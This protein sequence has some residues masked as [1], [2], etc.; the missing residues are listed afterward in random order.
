MQSLLHRTQED[1]NL[2]TLEP[3][4]Q[5]SKQK[6][7]MSLEKA[8]KKHTK[9]VKERKEE[10]EKDQKQNKGQAKVSEYQDIYSQ[11]EKTAGIQ[12]I[13]AEN[14][15]TDPEAT[16]GTAISSKSSHKTAS[17]LPQVRQLQLSI[18]NT[19]NNTE[20]LKKPMRD[21]QESIKVIEANVDKTISQLVTSNKIK[22]AAAIE[23]NKKIGNSFKKLMAKFY[24]LLNVL[25]VKLPN[26]QESLG[27]FTL[28]DEDDVNHFI[29]ILEYG[30]T[31]TAFD[32][33]DSSKSALPPGSF[34]KAKV[35]V[36]PNKPSNYTL[37]PLR[38]LE[39][40]LSDAA[41]DTF[42]DWCS[43]I[44]EKE[45]RKWLN[46]L[47]PCKNDKCITRDDLQSLCASLLRNWPLDCTQNFL[48]AEPLFE[49]EGYTSG[50]HQVFKIGE[51]KSYV[52]RFGWSL[53][54]KEHKD[55]LAGIENEK[56]CRISAQQKGLCSPIT[57]I[58][59]ST[60][61]S[62]GGVNKKRTCSGIT[63]RK[64]DY[65][66]YEFLETLVSEKYHTYQDQ[67]FKFLKNVYINMAAKIQDGV[68]HYSFRGGTLNL[69]NTFIELSDTPLEE[70]FIQGFPLI[71]KTSYLVFRLGSFMKLG[72]S[73][74]SIT[75]HLES[76][77]TSFAQGIEE[78]TKEKQIDLSTLNQ[79]IKTW[80]IDLGA[81]ALP[82]PLNFKEY[83]KN[84]P[85]WEYDQLKH[86]YGGI[87]KH[88][89]KENKN[90][91]NYI[92][93]L[94]NEPTLEST[95]LEKA[96]LLQILNLPFFRNYHIS[97]IR[98]SLSIRGALFAAN[99]KF[100]T[101]EKTLLKIFLGKDLKNKKDDVYILC[102]TYTDEFKE[103]KQAYEKTIGT[104]NKNILKLRFAE[105]ILPIASSSSK[106]TP[107][108][109][110]IIIDSFETL[111]DWIT[112]KKDIKEQM[113]PFISE[114]VM[115]LNESL[116]KTNL[117]GKFDLSDLVVLDREL[118]PFNV[119]S[120][121]LFSEP[122]PVF[123]LPPIK[124]TIVLPVVRYFFKGTTNDNAGDIEAQLKELF[125]NTFSKTVTFA[126]EGARWKSITI[127]DDSEA[128]TNIE[129]EGHPFSGLGD[130]F[131]MGGQGYDEKGKAEETEE[132][133]DVEKTMGEQ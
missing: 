48:I 108:L 118:S 34:Q 113:I 89:L 71:F 8:L 7:L 116:K 9:K 121:D 3:P 127:A 91:I 44:G 21:I 51:Y 56:Q 94:L 79:V 87:I 109:V 17:R 11:V 132:G 52:G 12:D 31:S 50:W 120:K 85:E 97:V 26:L 102:F 29:D 13:S 96:V 10:K 40:K 72:K 73:P 30:I 130:V 41:L 125:R 115:A 74:I 61:F 83:S 98:D 23:K 1:V 133:E 60:R 16:I 43:R 58:T 64:P 126:R 129:S 124:T 55:I 67:F 38:H 63:W 117:Q 54:D 75:E 122:N 24:S 95:D 37:K 99:S 35:R 103:I 39:S 68:N 110:F 111:E 22:Q 57:Q 88:I 25:E 27:N 128:Q 15:I 81:S 101:I 84:I 36:D 53:P 46:S 62:M 100:A 93:K 119:N 123:P 107:S 59:C 19:I 92:K 47:E 80:P 4:P 76:F 42:E 70:K 32:E 49:Y 66:L 112:D 5:S 6:G 28:E 82:K 14:I 65:S 2:R 77:R 106:K 114:Q 45:L 86:T 33:D 131:E 105:L 18:R 90:F 69:Q 20:K 104:A 78:I